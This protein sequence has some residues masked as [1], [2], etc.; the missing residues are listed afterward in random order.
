MLNIRLKVNNIINLLIGIA[1]IA[2]IYFLYKN[3]GNPKVNHIKQLCDPY[4]KYYNEQK[5]A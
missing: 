1:I 4:S 2:Y 3:R 5:A